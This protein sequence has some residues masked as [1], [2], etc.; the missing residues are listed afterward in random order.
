MKD[1]IEIK[2]R[3]KGKT[4]KHNSAGTFLDTLLNETEALLEETVK[5]R[6]FELATRAFS[7]FDTFTYPGLPVVLLSHSR[8]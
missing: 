6:H 3:P 5:E 2:V 7:F 8:C 4:V 1:S